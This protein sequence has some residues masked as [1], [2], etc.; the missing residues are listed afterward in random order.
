MSVILFRRTV[1]LDLIIWAK[2]HLKHFLDELTLRRNEHSAKLTFRRNGS[3]RNSF[4]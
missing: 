1:A 2:A 4:R 3:R